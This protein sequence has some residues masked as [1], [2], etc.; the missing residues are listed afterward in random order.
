MSEHSSGA[1]RAGGLADRAA[2]AAVVAFALLLWFAAVPDQIDAVDYGWMRPQTLPRICTAALGLFGALLI[3]RPGRGGIAVD[4]GEL[5]RL[6]TLLATM[7]AAV[8]AIGQW[9]FLS[10][11][12]VLAG[13]LALLLGERRWSWVLA[14]AC[15]APAAIWLVVSVLL[16]RPLP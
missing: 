6:A 14:A 10:V 9:N 4:I 12:P 5:A 15:G 16:Q 13:G 8:W 11:A 7:A 2:G 1:D 3:L